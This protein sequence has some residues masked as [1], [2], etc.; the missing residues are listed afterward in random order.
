MRGTVW[1]FTRAGLFLLFAFALTALGTAAAPPGDGC[2]PSRWGPAENK[3][4]ETKEHRDGAK[5]RERLPGLALGRRCGLRAE[6]HGAPLPRVLQ[7]AGAD[8]NEQR[9]RTVPDPG[10]DAYHAF[11]RL[12]HSPDTLQVVRH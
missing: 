6:A 4:S 8:E 11:V 9:P 3:Q 10:N 7:P 2:S 1:R 12:R 5:L